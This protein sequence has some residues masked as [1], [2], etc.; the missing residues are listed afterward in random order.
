[1]TN[2]QNDHND[3]EIDLCRNESAAYVAMNAAR[4]RKGM[5]YLDME[6]KSGVSV[7]SFWHYLRGK[8]SPTL[9]NLIAIAETCGYE[10]IMRKRDPE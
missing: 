3:N 10:V 6:E 1:M 5:S 7:N 9:A 2:S 4:V 8:R